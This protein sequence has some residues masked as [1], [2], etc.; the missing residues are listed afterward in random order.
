MPA[1]IRWLYRSCVWQM[2]S[3]E[4]AVYLTFDDGPH[5]EI[6]PWVLE[7]L[8]KWNV[9]ATFFCIGAR[10]VQYPEIMA[11]ILQEGHTVGNHTHTH[12]NGWKATDKVYLQDI[13]QAREFIPSG[14]FRP[15]Y[16]R[17]RQ[18]QIK[19]LVHSFGDRVVMWSLLSGDFDRSLS[20]EQCMRNVLTTIRSGDIVVFHD[21]EK[22]WERLEYCLPRILA[23]IKE[24]NWE[25]KRL[26]YKYL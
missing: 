24:Q 10:V 9:R 2:P 20:G 19:E 23:Y 16:G 18:S 26:E 6:T 21:S 22:A 5:P 13:E 15:P 12:L 14:L 3:A 4:P 7:Q 1:L 11:Q 25:G 8:R 17:I